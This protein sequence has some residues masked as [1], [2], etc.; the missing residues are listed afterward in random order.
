MGVTKSKDLS[1]VQLVTVFHDPDLKKALLEMFVENPILHYY[2]TQL[3]D[4]LS[5]PKK[6]AEFLQLHLK[7]L[8]WHLARLYRIRCCIVHGSEI[9][10][11]LRLFAANLEYY[12]EQMIRICISTFKNHD[13][14][15]SLQ[16]LFLRASDSYD[17]TISLLLTENASND[18]ILNAIF[19]DV[20][21]HPE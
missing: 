3:S 15:S 10:F 21:L 14:I 4:A 5:E 20:A 13:H 19:V 18:C 12:L 7:H 11:Q 8:E 9:I 17:R 6:T 2:L 1:I 16:E